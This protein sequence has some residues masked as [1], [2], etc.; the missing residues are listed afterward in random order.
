MTPLVA[1]GPRRGIGGSPLVG[2]ARAGSLRSHSQLTLRDERA[3]LLDAAEELL[4][5]HG[6]AHV[7]HTTTCAAAGLPTA[8]FHRSFADREDCLFTLFDELVD[9]LAA[10]IAAAFVRE[11]LWI[12][13]VRGALLVALEFLQAS[14]PRA[15]F[16]LPT[17]ADASAVMRCRRRRLLLEM[18]L[19][20]D[21]RRPPGPKGQPVA[22]VRTEAVIAAAISVVRARLL[23]DAPL[24]EL[25]PAL[26]AVLVMP[27]LGAGAARAEL[28]RPWAGLRRRPLSSGREL[29]ARASIDIR[30]R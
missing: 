26:M 18:S 10:Q 15:R 13:G 28:T 12:D 25:Y 9:V 29:H 5:T 8:A 7:D 6:A 21:A 17:D 4:C 2:S 1:G 3:R 20:F 27:Y 16:L 19:A 11:A 22:P 14:R 30:S 24:R 23:D